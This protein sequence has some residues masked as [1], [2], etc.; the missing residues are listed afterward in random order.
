MRR[1]KLKYLLSELIHELII[2]LSEL[3]HELI[4]ELSELIQT[5]R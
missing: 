4:I 5:I 1:L 3:I 2:E